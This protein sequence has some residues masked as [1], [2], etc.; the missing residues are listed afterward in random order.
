MKSVAALSAAPHL[1]GRR[2]DLRWSNPAPAD[3][4]GDPPLA[5]IRIVRRERSFP[6][7]PDD[8]AVLYDGDV[9]TEYADAGAEPLQSHYYTVFTVDAAA[10]CYAGEASRVSAFAT[11]AYGLAAALYRQLPEVHRRLDRLSPAERA[12]LGAPALAALDALPGDLGE[13]GPLSRLLRAAAAPLDLMRSTA[14][15][16]RQVHDADR[17][18]P[19]LLPL[20]GQWLGWELD[21]SLPVYAQRNEVKFAPG[22]YRQV[23]S[24]PSL[25]NLVTRTTGWHVQVAELAQH[26]ARANQP[27]ARHLFALVEDDGGWR[28]ADDASPLTGFGAGNRQAVG[29]AGTA[30]VLTGTVP[31]PFALRPGMQLTLGA[32]GRPPVTVR[33]RS[34]D[35]ADLGAATA[36][37]LAAVLDRT[38]SQLTAVALGDGRIELSSHLTG[39]TSALEVL[40]QAASLVSLE[41]APRG[42]PSAVADAG[43]RVRLCYPTADPTAAVSELAAAE[44]LRREGPNQTLLPGE[45]PPALPGAE[46]PA[47]PAEPGGRVRVKT[48][49]GG[50]WGE[51]RALAPA[52]GSP[53]GDPTMVELPGGRLWAAWI[54]DA[55]SAQARIVFATAEVGSPLPAVLAGDRAGP[56]RVTPGSHLVLAGN[57]P[58]A[59]TFRFAA[60]DFADPQAATAAEVAAALNGRLTRVTAA[61]AGGGNLTIETVAA[62]GEERLELDLRHSSAAAVLGFDAGNAAAAGDWG[63]GLDFSAPEEVTAAAPGRNADLHAVVGAG[64]VWLFWATHDGFG[65]AIMSSRWDGVA[66]SPAEALAEQPGSNREPAAAV[67]GAGNVWLVWSRR[68]GVGTAEDSWLLR[69]RVFDPGL[70]TW[71]AEQAVTALPPGGRAADREPSLT[72]LPGGDLGV[73]FRSD[74]GGGW[75]LVALEIALPAGVAGT[76]AAVTAGA[77]A[78]SAPAAIRFPDGELWLIHRSDRSLPLARIATR[79]RPVWENRITRPGPPAAGTLAAEPPPAPAASLRLADTG[80]LRRAS[81]TLSAVPADAA[82]VGRQRRWDDL[83]AYTPQRPEGGLLGD[84]DLYTRGTVGLYLSRV[85]PSSPLARRRVERL[86]AALE[87]FLPINVRAVVILAP[88]VDLEIVYGPGQD[89]GESYLDQY[90]LV[91]TYTG[92]DDAAAAA[93][94]D[95]IVLLSTTGDHVSADPADLTT[96][97]RRTFF[98]PPS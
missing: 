17:A 80:T 44:R 52:G 14:E 73:F 10:E 31:G 2:I 48:F 67:D 72:L 91:E 46:S 37:E 9:I 79:P 49:R 50:A 78:S 8:G 42:R 95:W 51:S 81:G 26:I 97:R 83:M 61:V 30:A 76:P 13:R 60:S 21:R 69:R 18:R 93:L 45:S 62:G 28:G 68:V 92:L 71:D 3:F 24:V 4:A 98:L 85:V 39:D 58:E 33:L 82:R 23:G 74:R 11:R 57:W 12:G 88:R 35:F 29:G 94:P 59:E 36:E 32:D 20:L 38:F 43:G 66:W 75:D 54:E 6:H 47:P 15:G 56:F 22:L 27:A 41:G 53:Q 70:A 86:R 40:P 63:D 25:R 16:L 64:V 1:S 65:H 19:D 5:G 7:H 84:E 89:I 77:A 55:G 87:R 90:P 34:G 96:L